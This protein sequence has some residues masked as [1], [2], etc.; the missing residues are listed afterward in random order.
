MYDINNKQYIIK[1]GSGKITNV[2]YKSNSGAYSSSLNKK[3]FWNE[4][5]LVTKD[6]LPGFNICTDDSDKIHILCQDRQGNIKYMNYENEK[7]NSK[8]ILRSRNFSPYD[9]HLTA[10]STEQNVHFFYTLHY[11]EKNLLS[12]QML[13]NT[14]ELS[15]PKVIDYVSESPSPYTVLSSLKGDLYLFYTY[16]DSKYSRVG[17]KKYIAAQNM[18]S[19]FSPIT[20]FNGESS[21]IACVNSYSGEL[22][23]CWQKHMGS[24]YELILSQKKSDSEE[25]DKEVLISRAP[26]PFANSSLV[27]FGDRLVAYWFKENT[28]L[29]TISYDDGQ[30][31]SKPETYSI[32]GNE[33]LHCVEYH[34]NFTDD[35]F[36]K[37]CTIIPGTIGTGYKLAFFDIK[38][39]EEKAPII[40]KVIPEEPQLPILNSLKTLSGEM[41]L[42]KKM[43]LDINN[44]LGILE[45]N[46]SQLEIEV[47]RCNSK[48]SNIDT[49]LSKVNTSIDE[50]IQENK[51]QVVQKEINQE[52]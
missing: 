27:P 33:Q 31:W 51:N 48:L 44:K 43:L 12:Y 36:Y 5:V 38:K 9:K 13:R 14:G 28:L 3:G 20:E 42:I 8:I 34:S 11:S 49:D 30:T 50:L 52:I 24:G 39:I 15:D 4:A 32:P 1:Q 2:L 16:Q 26:T 6:I 10:I 23:T 18:W 29:H 19:D 41:G 45:N 7:W 22:Y 21:I 25:W 35:E 37:R 47:G 40:S 17:Y 46:Q